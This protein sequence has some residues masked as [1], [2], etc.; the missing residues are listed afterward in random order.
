MPRCIDLRAP[1]GR[2]TVVVVLAE[3]TRGGAVES[4][5]AGTI[6]VAGVDGGVRA[7]AG[8]PETFAYFRSSAKPFQAVQVVESGAA[9]RYGFT[10]AELALCCASH[11]AEASHQIQVLAMLAKLGLDD[12]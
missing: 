8:D 10:P 7:W 6:V 3:L 9:D 1:D 11:S 5:H 12:S 4:V 2:G